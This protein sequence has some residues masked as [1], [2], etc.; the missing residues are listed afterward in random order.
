MTHLSAPRPARASCAR[1]LL[2]AGGAF[3]FSAAFLLVPAHA[4]DCGNSGAGFERWLEGFKREAVQQGVSPRTVRAALDGVTYDPRVVA[5]DRRQ[6]VFSQSFLEFAGRMVAAYRLQKGPQLM[7]RYASIFERIERDFGVPAPVIVAIWALESDFGAGVGD[8]PALRSMATLAW[9]CRRAEEFRPQLLDA[10]RIID[11][12]D[13]SPQEMIGPW[14]GE[15]GQT[16]FLASVY[17]SYA[18]DYDGDGRRD[19]MKSVP[20]VLAST[21]NYL[22]ALGWRRGEPWL[23]EVRVPREMPWEQA[24]LAIK[25]PRSH[26]ARLGVAYAS[27]RALPSDGVEASLLLPMGRNGPAFLAYENFGVFLE[28]NSSLVYATTVAYLAT[29]LAGAPPLHRGNG[30]VESL[31]FNEIK[32]LQQILQR[33]GYDVG[34][35]DGIIGEKTRDAVRRMQIKLGLPADGYPTGELLA[36]LAR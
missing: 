16:Q 4:Q 34:G 10:L 33:A 30:P 13:L 3:A 14:A 24:A 29:R 9:D 7:R 27:G 2:L 15:L 12:G 26:W 28:W 35:V 17:Y 31:S 11:R 20:D 36:R 25:H 22:K 32:R 23:E 6:T 8:M 21:A 18:V 1:R 5:R 19:L